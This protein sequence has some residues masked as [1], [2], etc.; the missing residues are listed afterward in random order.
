MSFAPRPRAG[1]RSVIGTSAAPRPTPI[2]FNPLLR[3]FRPGGPIMSA[4]ETK[5]RVI[6]EAGG[7]A[8]VTYEQRGKKWIG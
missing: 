1:N 8:G 5:A 4:E 3:S 2:F 7:P 6:Y